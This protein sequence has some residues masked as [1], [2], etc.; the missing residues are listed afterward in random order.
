M[1]V[2]SGN[3]ILSNADL[4]SLEEREDTIGQASWDGSALIGEV[5]SLV[6]VLICGVL[7]SEV[8]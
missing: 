6:G 5:S 1:V 7:I 8:S 2:A 4:W 3:R